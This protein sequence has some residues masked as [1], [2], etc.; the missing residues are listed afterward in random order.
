MDLTQKE[1]ETLQ[2][3]LQT[4]REHEEELYGYP[5]DLDSLFTSTQRRLFKRFDVVSINVKYPDAVVVNQ[6][7]IR[8]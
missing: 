6:G 7:K 2:M 5:D 3:M 1:F 4:Y 8:K